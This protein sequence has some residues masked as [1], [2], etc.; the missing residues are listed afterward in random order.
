MPSLATLRSDDPKEALR[1]SRQTV[2]FWFNAPREEYDRL[3]G[4]ANE[5]EKTWLS[6][7]ENDPEIAGQVLYS[8]WQREILN[9]RC[10][11][12]WHGAEIESMAM[13]HQY[14]S[15]IGIA[16]KTTIFEANSARTTM[17]KVL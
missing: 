9:E 13:W 5:W 16:F 10:A 17:P 11:W 7:N 15:R 3:Y 4:K 12:C 6:E 2:K 14:S 1:F 8:I